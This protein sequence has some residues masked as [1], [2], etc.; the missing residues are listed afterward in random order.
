[1]TFDF[2]KAINE[3]NLVTNP[4]PTEKQV[5]YAKYLSEQTGLDLPKE[6]TKEA[7]SRFIN[8]CLNEKVRD[9][10][11][12]DNWRFD[13]SYIEGLFMEATYDYLNN[14]F[15]EAMFWLE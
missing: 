2:S 9:R 1:M 14:L 5:E 15:A 12:A 11:L 10:I 4:P 8:E 3:A 6:F 7:Y 13:D